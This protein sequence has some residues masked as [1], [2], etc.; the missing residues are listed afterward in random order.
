[1]VEGTCEFR[2]EGQGGTPQ[3]E[4]LAKGAKIKLNEL[5]ALVVRSVA[6]A[7]KTGIL[8]PAHTITGRLQ[9]AKCWLENPNLED[10]GLG[11]KS[12]ALIVQEARKVV[13]GLPGVQK[14]ELLNLSDEVDSLLYRLTNLT[15][16]GEGNSPQAQLTARH[17]LY[18]L[19][20]LKGKIKEAVTN[21]VVEN[22]IDTTTPLKQF[23]DAVL[24]QEGTP[25]RDNHFT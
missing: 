21:R 9:Q 24:A 10:K 4:S 6:K 16:Q 7:E 17:L 11:T 23:T 8:Q 19:L 15:N 22:F 12:I 14:S 5:N 25:N 13:D 3:A 2:Q 1:M 18:K 20:E